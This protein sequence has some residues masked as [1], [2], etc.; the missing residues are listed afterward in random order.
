MKH[1]WHLQAIS[2]KGTNLFTHEP[3]NL[4]ILSRHFIIEIHLNNIQ[5]ITSH[6][7]QLG[8][9]YM[10][11]NLLFRRIKAQLT[12]LKYFHTFIPTQDVKLCIRFWCCSYGI[13]EQNECSCFVYHCQVTQIYSTSEMPVKMYLRKEV[14]RWN[15][16]L[17]RYEI[18]FHQWGLFEN[19]IFCALLCN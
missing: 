6:S 2:C 10:I 17:S 9:C 16:S 7:L 4:F 13:Y 14:L 19:L 11:C 1:N 5:T 12:F 8:P 3:A 18:P 15:V